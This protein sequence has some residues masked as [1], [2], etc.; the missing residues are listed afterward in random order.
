MRTAITITRRTSVCVHLDTIA[1]AGGAI[2]T[3]AT[4][5]CLTRAYRVFTFRVVRHFH[6]NFFFFFSNLKTDLKFNY[7]RH[8][9]WILE[10][11]ENQEKKSNQLSSAALNLFDARELLTHALFEIDWARRLTEMQ[12]EATS[13]DRVRS[14]YFAKIL[15]FFLFESLLMNVF[16][17]RFCATRVIPV[18]SSCRA[19]YVRRAIT[20]LSADSHISSFVERPMCVLRRI[21]AK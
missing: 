17:C 5:Q 9:G 20:P 14:E 18:C 13:T 1:F 16:V 11:R 19:L 8:S 4:R 10:T 7:P 15:F 6:D 2:P 3:A 21:D 12:T